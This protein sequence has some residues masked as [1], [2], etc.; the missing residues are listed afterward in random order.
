[1]SR[2]DPS[3]SEPVGV[4]KSGKP[5]RDDACL[6][7]MGDQWGTEYLVRYGRGPFMQ[8][9]R[10]PEPG[11]L[12][13]L[14]L[15]VKDKPLN[16]CEWRVFYALLAR[17]GYGG[18]VR[19]TQAAIAELTGIKQPAI[20]GLLSSLDRRHIIQIHGKRNKRAYLLNP[21]LIRK[22]D[23][24]ERR[25]HAAIWEKRGEAA[26]AAVFREMRK[27]DELE[28]ASQREAEERRW[29]EAQDQREAEESP[30]KVRKAA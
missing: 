28:I 10:R 3:T 13:K 12:T 23:S 5:D 29:R 21:Y 25:K 19:E 11:W 20:S 24:V 17:A 16:G 4:D 14:D 15:R 27:E 18:W 2:D 1:M 30:P 9:D 7:F 6:F 8:L 26:R 22:G